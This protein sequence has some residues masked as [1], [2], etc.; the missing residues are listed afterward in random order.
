VSDGPPGRVR[1][2]VSEWRANGPAAGTA[3][4]IIVVS[5]LGSG[6]GAEETEWGVK[7]RRTK[8]G[9]D[10]RGGEAEPWG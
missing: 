9:A 2:E 7:R 4:L 3:P 5:R 1:E 8:R 6:H 10:E